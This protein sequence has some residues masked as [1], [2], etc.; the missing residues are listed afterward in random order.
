MKPPLL[1]SDVLNDLKLLITDQLRHKDHLTIALSGGS[2]PVSLYQGLNRSDLEYDRLTFTLVDDRQVPD[3]HDHS[4]IKLVHDHLIGDRDDIHFL[5]IRDGETHW[6]PDIAILGMGED[7]HFASLF[8][9]MMAHH[10]AF[11]Q[12]AEPEIIGTPPM[13]DPLLPR[14]SM[15]MAMIAKIPN[16]MLLLRGQTKIDLFHRACTGQ[17]DNLPISRLLKIV[18]LNMNIYDIS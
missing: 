9:A 6:Q 13:G 14:L 2:S 3:N 11:D 1:K 12:T 8:P 17:D 10:A 4:N 15:N 18:G 16:L 7:G 5:P